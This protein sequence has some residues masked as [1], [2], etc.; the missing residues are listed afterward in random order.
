MLA[1]AILAAGE[2]RRMG[3]PKA[4]LPYRGRTFLEHLLEVIRHPRIGVVR[5]VLGAHAAQIRKEVALDPEILVINRDWEKGQLSSIQIAIGSLPYEAT[6]GLLIFPVDH[7]LISTA[8]VN[9]LID[10]FDRTGKRIIL[11]I[12]QG[13]RGHPVLFASS[14]YDELLKAPADVGAR[15]VVRA[16]ADDILEVA[17]EEEGVVLNLNDPETLKRALGSE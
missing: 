11:P 14:L 5:V 7:P 9:S 6:E 1:A 2:S 12:Y 15:A 3:G 4:L 17:T 8:L 10:G 13:R 16:H